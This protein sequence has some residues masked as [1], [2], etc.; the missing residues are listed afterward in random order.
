MTHQATDSH[1]APLSRTQRGPH[2][3]TNAS[4]DED[5]ATATDPAWLLEVPV[6]DAM[7]T[8]VIITQPGALLADAAALMAHHGV[9]RLPVLDHGRLVGVLARGDVL[10]PIARGDDA[11]TTTQPAAADA[12]ATHRDL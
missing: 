9:N 10:A 6:C 3:E 1:V 4:A 8:E 12:E 2:G 7:S 5:A 11:Q